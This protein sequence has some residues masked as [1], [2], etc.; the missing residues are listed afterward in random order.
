V[1]VLVVNG[2]AGDLRA[3]SLY[4]ATLTD[5]E[6][7]LGPDHPDSLI[8]RN[9]GL[10]GQPPPGRVLRVPQD[11]ITALERSGEVRPRLGDA[12]GVSPPSAGSVDMC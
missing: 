1:N 9:N 6:R 8:S 10:G 12:H 3:I 2:C 5:R 11:Q 7:V 4:E